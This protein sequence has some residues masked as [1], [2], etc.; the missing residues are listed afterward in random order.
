MTEIPIP[1]KDDKGMS[2]TAPGIVGGKNSLSG[3]GLNPVQVTVKPGQK[4]NV[5][6]SEIT[7]VQKT[8]LTTAE[9]TSARVRESGSTITFGYT[10]NSLVD[11]NGAISRPQ[12][13][14][15]TEA[16]SYIAKMDTGERLSFL[17][18]LY[19]RGLYNGSKPSTTGFAS[20]DIGAVQDFMLYANSK[21]STGDVALSILLAEVGS[22]GGGTAI[23]TTAKADIRSIFKDATRRMLGRDVP[24]GVIER[25]V[26][27]YEGQEI[28]EAKGGVKAPSLQVAAEAQ[29]EQQFGGEAKAIGMASLMDLMD[30]KIKGL[31]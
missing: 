21:R 23:R 26:K 24:P 13:D 31:A 10:G 18:K 1:V 19:S 20:K 2:T 30:K 7:N 14:P 17:N 9:S 6:E 12:Y 5:Q 4:V 22:V 25:F 15:N 11:K 3:D 27:A 16:Y 29:V 8:P 28:V